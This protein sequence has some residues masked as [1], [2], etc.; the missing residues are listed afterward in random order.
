MVSVW[1]HVMGID[2]SS[3]KNIQDVKDCVTAGH[4]TITLDK[5]FDVPLHPLT[6]TNLF[7]LRQ[8]CKIKNLIPHNILEIL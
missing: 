5:I 6:L 2:N 3:Y 8:F 4:N 7:S 1:F